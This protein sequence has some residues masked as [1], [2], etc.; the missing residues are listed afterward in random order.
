MTTPTE[1][2]RTLVVA[3][4]TASTPLLLDE[5][6]RESRKGARITVLVPPDHHDEWTPEVA[7]RMCGRAA[8]RDVATLDCGADALR[9]QHLGLPVTVVP[10]EPGAAVP[11]HVKTGLGDDWY[12]MAAQPAGRLG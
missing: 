5:I 7:Q 8:G 4:R 2:T 6:T 3:N 11:D 9:I 1:T 12:Y 10:P